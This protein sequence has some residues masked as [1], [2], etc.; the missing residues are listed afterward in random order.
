[1]PS[2]LPIALVREALEILT[3]KAKTPTATERRMWQ[4]EVMALKAIEQTSSW[5]K[6]K[7]VPLSD[8]SK[9]LSKADQSALQRPHMAAVANIIAQINAGNFDEDNLTSDIIAS[10]IDNVKKSLE[11]TTKGDADKL[12]PGKEGKNLRSL[13]SDFQLSDSEKN[14]AHA[15]KKNLV[16]RQL[17]LLIESTRSALLSLEH[18]KNSKFRALQLL[19]SKEL[20][21]LFNSIKTEE[22]YDGLKELSDK[23]A[24]LWKAAKA[25][26]QLKFPN[27]ATFT[28]EKDDEITREECARNA[29]DFFKQATP[30]PSENDKKIITQLTQLFAAPAPATIILEPAPELP[31]EPAAVV[32]AEPAVH[33]EDVDPI[34]E[35]GDDQHLEFL[36]NPSIAISAEDIADLAE[37][38]RDLEEARARTE[39][40]SKAGSLD[41]A[42]LDADHG[43]GDLVDIPADPTIAAELQ[44]TPQAPQPRL[45]PQ[46][47]GVP[48]ISHWKDATIDL[49]RW[50]ARKAADMPRISQDEQKAWLEEEAF[51]ARKETNF[52]GTKKRKLS[53]YNDITSKR[54]TSKILE[55]IAAR[56]AMAVVV[57]HLNKGRLSEGVRN[58][59]SAFVADWVDNV[60]R[61]LD[62]EASKAEVDAIN[63]FF[64]NNQNP[65]FEDTPA[66]QSEKLKMTQ[67]LV[68]AIANTQRGL[69]NL[70]PTT[71]P[72]LKTLLRDRLG[73]DRDLKSI[74][75]EEINKLVQASANIA[76]ANDEQI[77]KL[78]KVYTN[79]WKATKA[80]SQLNFPDGTITRLTEA[81]NLV[82]DIANIAPQVV[83]ITKKECASEA[84]K[85]LSLAR[86]ID[87]PEQPLHQPAQDPGRT[88]EL[89]QQILATAQVRSTPAPVHQE[90]IES[91]NKHDS[92][93]A[94]HIAKQQNYLKLKEGRDAPRPSRLAPSQTSRPVSL[95]AKADRDKATLLKKVQIFIKEEPKPE[96]IND[97]LEVHNL[98]LGA[99]DKTDQAR[100][101]IS[102]AIEHLKRAKD[103]RNNIFTL[104]SIDTPILLRDARNCKI[105]PVRGPENLEIEYLNIVKAAIDIAELAGK[106]N[107]VPNILEET[108]LFNSNFNRALINSLTEEKIANLVKTAI[109]KIETILAAADINEVQQKLATAVNFQSLNSDHFNVVTLSSVQ[110]NTVFE[111]DVALTGITSAQIN[112]YLRT[113]NI[114]ADQRPKWFNALPG[115]HQELVKKYI[116]TILAGNHVLPAQLKLPG[117]GNASERITGVINR[118]NEVEVVHSSKH[119]GSLASGN[120]MHNIQ[121]AKEWIGQGKM[122]HI[123]DF[124]AGALEKSQL[125]SALT[126]ETNVKYTNTA[127]TGSSFTEG[128]NA[129]LLQIHHALNGNLQNKGKNTDNLKIILANLEPR[130]KVFFGGF[131]KTISNRDSAKDPHK[132]IEDLPFDENTKRLLKTAINLRRNLSELEGLVTISGSENPSLEAA[133]NLSLLTFLAAKTGIINRLREETLGVCADGTGLAMHDQSAK[134]LA[135]KLNLRVESVNAGLVPA[136]H[137]EQKTGKVGRFDILAPDKQNKE[138]KAADK[139]ELL[140]RDLQKLY[141]L[142]RASRNVEQAPQPSHVPQD[143]AA[144]PVRNFSAALPQPTPAAEYFQEEHQRHVHHQ[145][146]VYFRDEPEPSPLAS[147]ANFSQ[148]FPQQPRG[149]FLPEKLRYDAPIPTIT[150]EPLYT[151][152]EL[153][154]MRASEQPAPVIAPVTHKIPSLSPQPSY[155]ATILSQQHFTNTNPSPSVPSAAAE[156]ALQNSL[157]SSS[158][159]DQKQ[160]QTTR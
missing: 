149:E 48:I 67:K 44:Q 71:D 95:K 151:I 105:P 133:S 36:Q 30:N 106:S 19:I 81:Q 69:R 16:K 94:K 79:L 51:L 116:P 109:S 96:K 126:F 40:E 28:N 5:G 74:I 14:A 62:I 115:W 156:R 143:I 7:L 111:A 72:T 64:Y 66:W 124:N 139:S 80:L 17:E 4:N 53:E 63:Q 31:P 112:E 128:A 46:K 33:H 97:I 56:E 130:P 135:A 13:L 140:S 41:P 157:R 59:D 78:I 136:R 119:A 104:K 8:Y 58:I 147:S 42:D 87:I 49:I 29:L 61:S 102:Q 50:A 68:A 26:S 127:F 152:A 38:E 21:T 20:G 153:L 159:I 82:I 45:A 107:I 121:Q 123:D 37:M 52:F 84:W 24:N 154:R 55:V 132:A 43:G 114:N 32:E 93:E 34:L 122:L 145:H 134:A 23:Y 98:L 113:Y 73:D 117:M 131:L 90:E 108:L 10:W 47:A 25:F 12:A 15:R 39:A 86:V 150:R 3:T 129:T 60:K 155:A 1:M 103:V 65:D 85:F 83:A 101:N 148:A 75:E 54:P 146:H 142:R 138:E 6:R 2:N 118:D 77:L 89:N 91:E 35:P 27:G 88:E 22:N 92:D 11:I 18:E 76:S 125:G 137:A 141:K 99:L 158:N 110:G 9:V 57:E 70:N 100:K 144:A 120:S 160:P